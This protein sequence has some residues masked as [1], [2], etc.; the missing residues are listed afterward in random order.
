MDDNHPFSEGDSPRIQRTTIGDDILEAIYASDQDMYPAPLPYKR[1]K[2]WVEASPDLCVG[3][4]ATSEAG[5]VPVGAIITLPLL[6][7]HWEDILV[8]KLKETD[9]EPAMFARDGEAE[10]GLHVFHIE[11]FDTGDPS[12]RIRSFARFALESIR[13]VAEKKAWKVLG[14]SGTF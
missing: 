13:E 12:T 7:R 8:G 14:Y 5:P 1:L 3:F 11:R 6:R 4:E 9:I 2:S 10:V